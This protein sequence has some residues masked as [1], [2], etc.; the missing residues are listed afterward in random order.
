MDS[1]AL[2]PAWRKKQAEGK[3]SRRFECEQCHARYSFLD[4]PRITRVPRCPLCGS[5]NGHPL[6]A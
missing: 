3:M 4:S 5:F 1:A 2:Q 6:A